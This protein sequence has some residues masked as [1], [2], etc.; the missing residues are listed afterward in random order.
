MKYFSILFLVL[1][2]TTGCMSS[3][4][5]PS[6]EVVDETSYLE[7]NAQKDGVVVTSSGLQ[8]RIIEEGNGSTPSLGSVVFVD[9]E[10]QLINGDTFIETEQLDYFQ[11]TENILPGLV[12][13]IQ[14]MDEGAVYEFVL[15]SELGYD[16][17]P[18]TGTS[19]NC[20]S[21]LIFEIKLDSFLRDA[22]LFMINNA[23][24]EDIEIT[25]S[26][27]QYRVI[28]EGEGEQP[29]ANQVVTIRYSG[30][31]T[32][33]YV[34]DETQGNDTI[35]FSLG[36]LIEGF[37]EGVRLMNRGAIYEIFLPPDLAYGENPPQGMPP[38]VVLI[39]EVELVDF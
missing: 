21:V 35:D 33:G 26:G 23:T 25:E 2:F 29:E 16:E 4:S 15:P 30:S 18:P 9:Y 1:L 7:E 22:D 32:N 10:G 13:G 6:C 19:I 28:K 34:F 12:E 39:F 38:N 8:Y 14:L 37:S 36:Q 17:N 27:L 20:G 3:P 5:S 24:N 11:L 31:F